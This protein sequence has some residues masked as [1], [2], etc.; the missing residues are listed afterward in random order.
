M[1]RQREGALVLREEPTQR[2]DLTHLD[3]VTVQTGEHPVE[4]EYVL[5][6]DQR[7]PPFEIALVRLTG[8]TPPK[9]LE[10]ALDGGPPLLQAVPVRRDDR[11]RCGRQD[12]RSERV[13]SGSTG[14]RTTSR[15]N[16]MH[17]SSRSN[18]SSLRS[19]LPAT[20]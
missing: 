1:S 16:P 20:N 10:I 19:T 5:R 6:L 2:R 8:D 11:W 12:L 17:D 13:S 15:R 7:P 9:T 4:P 3:G 14:R 18:C